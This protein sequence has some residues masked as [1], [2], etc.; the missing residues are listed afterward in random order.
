[1]RN[2]LN[3]MDVVLKEKSMFV[4]MCTFVCVYV[5]ARGMKVGGACVYF[6]EN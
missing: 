3:V 6:I 5:F 2:K 4:C 1:M